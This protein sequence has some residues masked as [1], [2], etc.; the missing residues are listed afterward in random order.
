MDVRRDPA[1]AASRELAGRLSTAPRERHSLVRDGQRPMR[2]P[3][4]LLIRGP[5][6][7][8]RTA[9]SGLADDL[10]PRTEPLR[11]GGP[12]RVP[13]SRLVRDGGAGRR[14]RLGPGGLL[15]G[16]PEAEVLL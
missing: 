12:R 13:I 8:A 3:P 2:F 10:R 7:E 14:L 6:P 11:R 5:R 4:G 1:T 9:D 16:A 15:E